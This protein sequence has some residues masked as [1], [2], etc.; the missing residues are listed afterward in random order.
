MKRSSI[1]RVLEPA[2]GWMTLVTRQ[3]WYNDLP[4]EQG[5]KTTPTKTLHDLDRSSSEPNLP[6]RNHP[7]FPQLFLKFFW[8]FQGFDLKSWL[9]C[10]PNLFFL[11][12]ASHF[13]GSQGLLTLFPQGLQQ[14]VFCRGCNSV[15]Y[16]GQAT[17]F[18]RILFLSWECFQLADFFFLKKWRKL[19][20][21]WATQSSCPLVA[22]H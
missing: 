11:F 16:V 15:S 9:C 22:N 21:T 14:V 18:W 8:V 4:L 2:P 12:S 1:S 13:P 10:F 7:F 5:L 6:S 19:N 20:E 17:E 3:W